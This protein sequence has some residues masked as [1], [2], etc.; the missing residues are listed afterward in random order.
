MSKTII[1]Q[2]LEQHAIEEGVVALEEEL[3]SLE[4]EHTTIEE[5]LANAESNEAKAA[6]EEKRQSSKERLAAKKRR[7]LL[8][9]DP[10][11]RKAVA[12]AAK[13]NK[14]LDKK[15]YSV[16]RDDE[17]G[18]WVVAKIDLA[19]SKAARMAAKKRKK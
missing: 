8:K 11:Y 14:G 12:K 3:V 19:K 9:K 18:S 15:K 13:M 1:G 2:L 5:E 7:L 17:T 16:Q 4:A 6:L 10:S